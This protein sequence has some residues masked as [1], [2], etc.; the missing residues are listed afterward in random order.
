MQ[1]N[2]VSV[3]GRRVE[4]LN[5]QQSYDSYANLRLKST[6][7]D[8]LFALVAEIDRLFQE[9]ERAEKINQ[10]SSPEQ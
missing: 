10:R 5:Y 8:K 9:Y 2:Y 6:D 4:C 7:S 3:M 1:C